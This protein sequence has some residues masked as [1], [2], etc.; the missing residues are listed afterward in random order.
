MNNFKKHFNFWFHLKP[1]SYSGMDPKNAKKE[2]SLLSFKW[3]ISD[4]IL[5]PGM[6]VMVLLP[7]SLSISILSNM[8]SREQQMGLC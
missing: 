7:I 4:N 3:F 8:C 2:C 1:Y 6:C 5:V